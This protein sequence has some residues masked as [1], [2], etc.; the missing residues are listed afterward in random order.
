MKNSE[1]RS[2]LRKDGKSESGGASTGA[3]RKPTLGSRGRGFM[4][5]TPRS[6]M[7]RSSSNEFAKQFDEHTRSASGEPP[8][9]KFK[10]TTVPKGT[11][12]AQGY[13]DR[14]STRQHEE[15]E[16]SDKM[17]KLKELE[18]M[19]KEEKIDRH[20]FEK[21][22]DQMGIGGDLG[23]THLVKGLDFKLL[24]KARK[25]EDLDAVTVK[26]PEINSADIDDEFDTVVGREITSRR[27]QSKTP[28][29]ETSEP[30]GLQTLSRNEI[31]RRLREGRNAPAA[32]V[33]EH[34]LGDRFKKMATQEKP[35]KKKFIESVNGRRREVLV[36]TKEDGT[37]KRKTRW[38]DPEPALQ[39]T[40]APLG[41]EVPAEFAARQKALAEQEVAE[42]EDDDI[43]A[44]VGADYDPLKDV[45]SDDEAA[46]PVLKPNDDARSAPP[47]NYFRTS[48]EEE[49]EQTSNP[50]KHDATLMA[51]LKRAATIRNEEGAAATEDSRLDQSDKGKQFLE[52]LKEQERQD[53]RDMDLGFGAS[54]FGEEDDD[55]DGPIYD[56][57]EES[58]KQ[59]RKRGPK[60]RKGN[61]DNVA[62]VMSVLDGR[63]K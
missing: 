13:S 18:A 38:L 61:K 28:E 34:T 60:K 45:E 30:A 19:M 12:L 15:E 55:D 41:M 5:M 57:G 20:T 49:K 11:K 4:P 47:R 35:G 29:A 33:P 14:A 26:Q 31:L 1:F 40:Q 62:D 8:A 2:L 44:G 54:R 7:G 6:V 43:F 63:K 51:A 36:I 52:K 27:T 21:L 32:S 10:S 17:K 23:T 58:S 53:A 50:I 9:K 3:F 22:R 56:D 48:G 25:G 24:D 39:K 59:K 42:D 46:P 37:A 16:E